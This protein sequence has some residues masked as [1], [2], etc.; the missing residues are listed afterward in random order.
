MSPYIMLCYKA[1][2]KYLIFKIKYMTPNLQGFPLEILVIQVNL[3][4]V[5]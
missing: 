1:D 5:H 4:N 2:F 3:S